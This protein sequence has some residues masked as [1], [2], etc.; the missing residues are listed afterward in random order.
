MLTARRKAD[1]HHGAACRTDGSL[2]TP[3]ASPRSPLRNSLL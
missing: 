1:C 2:I 3:D